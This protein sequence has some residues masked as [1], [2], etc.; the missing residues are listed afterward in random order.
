ME[1]KDAVVLITGGAIRLGKAHGL[2]LA[3]KGAHIAFS[4]LPNEPGLE[5]KAEIE[6]LGVRCTATELDVRNLDDLRRICPTEHV[7]KLR[8]FLEFA[9]ELDLHEVP[10][11]Y[12]GGPQGFEHVL[13]L[14]EA[15]ARGLIGQIG[16]GRTIRA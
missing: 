15:A 7:H 13:D 3:R 14:C 12:Y 10:D 5:T 6:A 1:I 16:G 4:Y 2:Y 8:L 9:P 11:P